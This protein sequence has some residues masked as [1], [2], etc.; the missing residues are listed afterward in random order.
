MSYMIP[1]NA[2]KPRDSEFSKKNIYYNQ[3]KIKIAV[4]WTR[5]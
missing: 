3:C 2:Q 1:Y 4:L 5:L